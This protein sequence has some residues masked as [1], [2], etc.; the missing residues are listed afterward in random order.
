MSSWL[1][2][3]LEWLALFNGTVSPARA[4]EPAGVA[5]K[6]LGMDIR[7]SAAAALGGKASNAAQVFKPYTPP[8]GVLPEGVKPKFAMD[9]MSW[10]SSQFASWGVAGTQFLG[11]PYLS[12]LAQ[13]PEYRMIYETIAEEM[14]R[15][16]IEIKSNSKDDE[17]VAEKIKKI[18]LEFDRLKVQKAFYQSAIHDGQ[19]GCGHIFVCLGDEDKVS[20]DE[21]MKPIGDGRDDTSKVKIGKT[22]PL[23]ALRNVE[24]I[25]C[26]PSDYDSS[27]PLSKHWYKPRLWYVMGKPVS[28]TRLLTVVGREVP[29]LLKPVYNFGG[30]SLSQLAKSYVDIWLKTK[31]SVADLIFNFS[32]S[33]VKTD[34]QAALQGGDFSSY[35]SLSSR[36]DMMNNVRSNRGLLMLDMASEDFVNVSTPLGG[37]HEL[38]AQSQEHMSSVSKIPLVK[39]T[40]ISPSGLNA[41]SEGEIQVFY[42]FIHA[43]QEHLFRD[44]LHRVLCM[45]QLSLFNEIDESITFE[46]RPLEEESELERAE[47]RNKEAN[48]DVILIDAGVLSP[49]DSRKRLASDP[50]SIYDGLDPE[51][52]PDLS[53]EEDE[54]LVVHGTSA[55]AGGAD[56]SI[57]KLFAERKAS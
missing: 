12:E 40:G 41:S 26:Y 50:N 22:N 18:E 34:M 52:V 4:P 51:D 55:K 1:T 5:P 56:N 25:W 21:L 7:E 10:A 29:D 20:D 43:R 23:T 54:G 19:F 38:Q 8:P 11:Y 16:W 24:P 35:N 42:D 13:R 3:G 14:T 53:E 32:V 49:E 48:T 27:N 46:F 39:L 37:L 57:D 36:A 17:A 33:V 30:L 6:R 28:A 44:P 31:Q 9:D 15:K 2:R 47:R 45:V